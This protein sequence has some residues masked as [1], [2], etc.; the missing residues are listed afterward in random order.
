MNK[1]KFFIIGLFLIVFLSVSCICAADNET[2]T[3]DSTSQNTVS[4]NET[5][6][7]DTYDSEFIADDFTAKYGSSND[8]KVLLVDGN[9]DGIAGENVSLIWADGN[10]SPMNELKDVSGYGT[11]ITRDAGSYNA[12]VVLKDSNHTAKPVNVTIKITKANV[13]MNAKVYYTVQKQYAVLKVTVKDANGAL[14]NQGSVKFTINGQSYRVDVKKGVASKKV[15]LSKAKTYTYKATFTSKNY[16][17]K[18]ATSKVHVYSSSKSA[19]TFSV[20]GYKTVV[21]LSKFKKLVE[22]KN[23]K[24]PTFYELKTNKI[25][26]QK[27]RHYYSGNKYVYKTVKAR[28]IIS[29]EYGGYQ[30]L[31]N[32]PVN[33]YS[34]FLFTKYQGPDSFCTPHIGGLKICGD[35]GKLNKVKAKY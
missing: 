11:H 6:A 16:N 26:K 17:T 18:S 14:V 28:A 19:R 27:Y 7:V 24:K 5:D 1:N 31:Q 8:Y 10:E 25:I 13:K 21:P 4:V 29:I 22:A 23:T 15:R 3:D 33:K 2:V 20:K 12:T 30:G 35:I 34:L 32:A 9:G